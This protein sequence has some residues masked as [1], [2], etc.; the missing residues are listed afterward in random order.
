MVGGTQAKW[1]FDQAALS[2]VGCRRLLGGNLATLT[3]LR[4]RLRFLPHVGAPLANRLR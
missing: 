3:H 4:R 1:A 2:D